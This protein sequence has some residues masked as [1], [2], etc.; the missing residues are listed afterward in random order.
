L[1]VIARQSAVNASFAQQSSKQDAEDFGCGRTNFGSF[2]DGARTAE[3]LC[4]AASKTDASGA[5]AL[6]ASLWIPFD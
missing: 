1:H 3:A 6:T 5:C 4:S 2:A